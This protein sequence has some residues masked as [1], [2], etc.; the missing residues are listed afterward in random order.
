MIDKLTEANKLIGEI[1]FVG[2]GTDLVHLAKLADNFANHIALVVE[3]LAGAG[4]L[5]NLI[6]QLCKTASRMV[7][8][9]RIDYSI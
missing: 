3:K 6:K 9:F 8:S 2:Y 1:L 4:E 7:V 5:K